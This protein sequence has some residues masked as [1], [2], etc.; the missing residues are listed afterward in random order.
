MSKLITVSFD[1]A[2]TYKTVYASTLHISPAD[3]DLLLHL[4]RSIG[5]HFVHATT[6]TPDTGIIVRMV[7]LGSSD[8]WEDVAVS[9]ADDGFTPDFVN[10]IGEI[11]AAGF[12]AVHFD[13]DFDLI[14]TLKWYTDGVTVIPV[15]YQAR[16]LSF[17]ELS[18]DQQ[19]L[20]RNDIEEDLLQDTNFMMLGDVL[21]NETD[22][23]AVSSNW[24]QYGFTH[25]YCENAFS[26]LLISRNEDEDSF[27]VI[28]VVSEG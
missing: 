23:H 1:T 5:V 4:A 14:D 9:L 16:L 2:P 17:D 15:A 8:E 19:N 24:N 21:F 13:H 11:V 10:M 22:F 12:D 3:K 6:Q 18:Q 28:R 20:A 25:G 7:A 26:S 27:E